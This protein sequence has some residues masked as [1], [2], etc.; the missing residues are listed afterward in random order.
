[1]K[2]FLLS[3][4]VVGSFALY[5][6]YYGNN[7]PL[8]YLTTTNITETSPQLTLPNQVLDT[9]P[10]NIPTTTIPTI[11]PRN[12]NERESD[13]NREDGESFFS[14]PFSAPT[15][16][17]TPATKPI[18]PTTTTQPNPTTKTGLYKNGTYQGNPAYA[19]TGNIIIS[20]TI[21]GGKITSVGTVDQS[22][23]GTS[24]RINL[25]ALPTLKSE[26]IQTQNANVN[27]VSG[28]TYTSE[29]FQQ[30]LSSALAQAKN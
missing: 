15:P 3:F 23:S 14:N 18:T 16:V 12:N 27:I 10:T 13:D 20:A 26:A 19:Y 4:F 5:A 7:S 28:A 2:K 21:S 8:N 17:S 24:R 1:M 6:I 29:A 30:S 22:Q 25:N 9:V 11:Q